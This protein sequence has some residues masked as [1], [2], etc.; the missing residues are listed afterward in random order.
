MIIERTFAHPQTQAEI[1]ETVG[2]VFLNDLMYILKQVNFHEILSK[3]VI[4]FVIGL[5]GSDIDREAYRERITATSLDDD[6]SDNANSGSYYKMKQRKSTH[7][8]ASAA[9]NK[10]MEEMQK[11]IE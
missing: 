10:K 8:G 11:E 7:N 6:L 1:V 5:N 2:I 3:P 4:N 9:T